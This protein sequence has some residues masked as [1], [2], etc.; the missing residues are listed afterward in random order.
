MRALLLAALVAGFTVL[1]TANAGGYRYGVSDQA[2]YIPAISLRAD[3][4]LFPRDR[5]VF[6]PQMRLWI[7]DEVLGAVVRTTNVPLPVLFGAIYVVTMALMVG[8]AVTLARALGLGW[9]ATWL[10]L[11]V[12]TLRHR[13][14][15]TGANS[16]E[17]YMHPR[18]L[19]FA[20][21][22]FVF[23]AV[24]RR[25]WA[26][27]VGL[28]V[29]G[30]IVHTSTAMWFAGV[31]LV[32]AVWATGRR[33]MLLGT[34][35]L[36]AIGVPLLSIAM[37]ESFPRMDA[38]W[39]AVL[40]ERDYLFSLEWPFYAWVLNL[41]YVAVLAALL[42]FRLRSGLARPG[43]TGLA[44]GLLALVVVFL[45][46]L[47]ATEARV[48][49]FVALQANRVFWLLDATLAILGAWWLMEFLPRFTHRRFGIA[50]TVV[51]AAFAIGRGA[52]VLTT[53]TN[54]NL[55]Q[56]ALPPTT[57]TDA[58]TWLRTQPASWNVLADPGH[59]WKFGSSVRVAAMRDVPLEGGKD[60]AMA[61]Y[62]HALARRVFDRSH[63]LAAFDS[64]TL[65]DVRRLDETY[66][67]DVF[68]DTTSRHFDLP[69]LFRNQDFVAYDLR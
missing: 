66:R 2:F 17:G 47:P 34:A 22:L 35:A 3:P 31:V 30:G 16:L 64:F 63:A 55:V 51:V 18:M 45:G 12:L 59:A 54:R 67:F 19:A 1:A 10:A 27:A 39:L 37:P 11:L 7:G 42:R 4:S 58:M 44:A 60:P 48:A 15:K 13:I 25:R 52:Y 32:A 38:N 9:P 57:W 28:V 61:M 69:V 8:G 62:D 43:E 6:E 14:P 5:E 24:V 23:A 26:T 53:E 50:I 68:V 33:A 29:I 21:G 40:A 20:I 46:T 49:F 41:S 65:A 36:L 56:P